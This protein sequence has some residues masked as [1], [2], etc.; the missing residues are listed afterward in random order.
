MKISVFKRLDY[1]V[2]IK[3][4]TLLIKRVIKDLLINKAWQKFQVIYEQKG[5]CY[6]P[7][8]VNILKN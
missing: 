6:T 1:P 3:F 7:S 8:D 5:E 4:D 2:L